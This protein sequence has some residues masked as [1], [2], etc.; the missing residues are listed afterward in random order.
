MRKNILFLLIAIF[1]VNGFSAEQT[2]SQ[3]LGTDDLNI[4]AKE[5]KS[6]QATPGEH[7]LAFKDNF[8]LI[9][10]D[11][12]LK[13]SEAIVWL[14]TYTI[15]YHGVTKI[16][17]K[18]K[19]YLQGNVSVEQGKGAKTNS[20]NVAE[21][22][23]SGVESMVAEFDVAG[24]IFATADTQTTED[25]RAGELYRNALVATGQIK[26]VPP[27]AVSP[28]EISSANTVPTDTMV[29]D[30]NAV[31]VDSETEA[32][33]ES[34]EEATAITPSPEAP[35]TSEATL[36]APAAESQAAA[37]VSTTPKKTSSVKKV[38]AVKAARPAKAVA[39]KT[40]KIRT[41]K[42][43]G[44]FAGLFGGPEIPAQ[45]TPE[46][47]AP[48]FK[49]PVN[50]SSLSTEP[51]KFTTQTLADGS[52][53]GTMRNRFYLWQKKDEQ[54]GLLEFQADAAVIFYEQSAKSEHSDAN[55]I[56]TGNAVK[57]AYFF[58]NVV[59]TEGLR[60]IRSDEAYYDFDAKQG[61]AVNA[62]MRTYEPDR[63]IPVYLKA[64]RLKQLSE[65]KFKGENVVLTNSEFYVPR[66]S[67][68][69]S[70]IIVTDTTSVDAQAG[71][72]GPQ[73]YDA[74]LRKVK[75]KI[76]NRTVF[77]WPKFR[78]SLK[79][80]DMPLRR[81]SLGSDSDWGTIVETEWY[82]ARVLGLKEAKGVDSSLFVDYYSK[83]GMGVGTKIEYEKPNS[84][85]NISGY[86]I[87][88]R[89]RDDL[90][91]NRQNIEPPNTLR[92]NFKF[93]HRQFL[94]YNWQLTLETSYMSDE[95]FAESFRRNE[96]LTGKEEETLVQL[97]R[98]KDNW[99]FAVMGKWRINDFADQLE[100]LPSAQYH[101][102]GQ[103]IFD[104]K[105]TLYHDSSVGSFRQRIGD[106]HTTNVSQER[107]MEAESRTELDLP[108][109][110]GSG[111]VVPFVA[112]TFGYDDRSGF[113]RDAVTSVNRSAYG[114]TDVFIG[115]VGT[116]ASTQYWKTYRNIHSEFWDVNGIRHIVKPYGSVGLFAESD[117]A[118]A[119][120]DYINLGLLQRLQTK[121]G[122][123]ERQRTVDWM[124]LDTSV[125][126]VS[127]DEK[128]IRRPDKFLWNNSFVPMSVMSAPEI[129]N[130]DTPM[131]RTFELYGPQRDS[132]NADYIWRISDTFAFLSDMNYDLTSNE[133][134]Q[135]NVGFSKLCLPNLSYYVGA[136]YLRSTEINDGEGTIEKGSNAAT[137][138]IT[139]KL[140]PRYTI[141]LAHQYDFDYSKRIST[142]LSLIR[143]YHRLYY[144]IT[145][146]Q[147]E[148]L[149]SQSIV[150]NIWPEGGSDLGFGSARGTNV[151]PPGSN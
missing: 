42:Q 66:I 75:L 79:G 145:F 33:A 21:S 39:E 11:N 8:K 40:P 130:G 65:N 60:T 51:V 123:G 151:E 15:D 4:S 112:G 101:L 16:E 134:E 84:F 18:I 59:M 120:K 117:S 96:F 23:M 28:D 104:D 113:A 131:Y 150:L 52:S 77:A 7:I 70:E 41:V 89:G 138:A 109:K 148:T 116:R 149:D 83:R 2:A 14:K 46:V 25:V 27:P 49:Y 22:K 71:E 100:E 118:V 88:D 141:V 48:K 132:F 124:R 92:G 58:G 10:G 56:V 119:Q 50:I 34:T 63:G 144:G 137:F 17:H 126:F 26:L 3:M 1:A 86:I 37:K 44:M 146:T 6:F 81:A 87:N 108:L 13:S 47:P 136:R 143:R 76:D 55:D 72:A 111:K 85:G 105:F 142:Q 30:S 147:D 94:P 82:L 43:P 106:R 53:I 20:V 67:M 61:L 24:E 74:E 102:K 129:F 121:R 98:L 73:S 68:T 80:S 135:F 125:T 91:R 12:Y 93:Q 128:N 54:G 107:F 127:D 32:E 103:S 57:A 140:S 19:V 139:Y 78:T 64:E 114:A 29:S 5:M 62:V 31:Q 69:A 9:L 36:T 45:T 97:R 35:A 133:I 90:G 122:I 99:A 38:K 95:N 110:V 115:E